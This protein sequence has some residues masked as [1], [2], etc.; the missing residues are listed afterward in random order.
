MMIARLS[1]S[2]TGG[3][4]EHR[5]RRGRGASPVVAGQHV[6][7]V[8]QDAAPGV[9]IR[10]QLGDRRRNVRRSTSTRDIT[11]AGAARFSRH[12]RCPAPPAARRRPAL[13]AASGRSLRIRR[14][15]QTPTRDRR[16]TP[17]SASSTY[18]RMA[19][20]IAR[21]GERARIASRSMRGRASGS[22]RR[23]RDARPARDRRQHRTRAIKR[24]TR[25]RSKQRT[26]V[27]HDRR[28]ADR[29]RI[30]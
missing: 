23:S 27:Q 1:L 22:R 8:A 16:A 4:L 9:G 13:R 29:E 3:L 7:G 11:R 25:R 26:D 12:R 21:A 14:G 10:Q 19:D 5:Q 2:A 28:T 6:A 18:D 30:V 17:A 15:T 20:A 24:S